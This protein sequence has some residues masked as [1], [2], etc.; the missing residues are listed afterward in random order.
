MKYPLGI[1]YP[2][3]VNTLVDLYKSVAKQ[4]DVYSFSVDATGVGGAPSQMLQEALPEMRVDAFTFTNKNKRELV[5]KVKVLHSYGKLKF[6]TRRGDEIYNRT[7][8][9]SISEMKQLQA[10]VLRDD[11]SNPEL[12]VFK[13]GQH[14]DLFTA[15]ALAVK[16]VTFTQ[17]WGEVHFIED[18]TWVQT[19][20]TE[21]NEPYVI[22]F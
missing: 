21:T 18:K 8:T 9:E 19:P 6:A 12:E 5:G 16:D 20:L 4:G 17:S 15:L 22:L 14:D 11:P 10:R 2:L 13:T 1:V 3:L 7:L